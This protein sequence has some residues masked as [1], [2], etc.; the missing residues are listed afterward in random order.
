MHHVIVHFRRSLGIVLLMTLAG[1]AGRPDAPSVTLYLIRH[2][3]TIQAEV[4]PDRPLNG[5]GRERARWLATYFADR[6][7]S[8][9]YS[10][11]ITRTRQTVSEIQK[12]KGLEVTTYDPRALD[13]LADRLRQA[14]AAT[15]VAGHS[16]TTPALLNLL[17][18][19]DRYEQLDDAEHSLIFVV[20][21]SGGEVS[22]VRIDRSQALPST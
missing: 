6:D 5:Q 7:L 13:E 16:N 9:I 11:P 21:L 3:E 2:A 18:K 15:L 19:E 4:D 20:T 12:A 1:C 17:L 14:S 22:G 8:V 10:T